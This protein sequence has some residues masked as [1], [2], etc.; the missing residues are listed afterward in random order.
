QIVMLE[1]VVLGVLGGVMGVAVG[2]LLALVISSLGIPMPPPPNADLSYIALI[3][4]TS[5]ALVGAFA[6]GLLAT[7]LAAVRPAV[8]VSRMQIV[9]ALRENA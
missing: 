5:S 4:V 7:L 1:N 2:T 8:K 9:D 6:I 3:R